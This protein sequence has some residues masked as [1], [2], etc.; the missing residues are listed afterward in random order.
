[1]RPIANAQLEPPGWVR[2]LVPPERTE[3]EIHP[4]PSRLDL[5]ISRRCSPHSALISAIAPG[6]VLLSSEAFRQMTSEVYAAILA[7]IPRSFHPAR[8]WNHIPDIHAAMGDGLDRYMVFNLGRRS[9]LSEHFGGLRSIARC[10]PTATGVGHGSNELV[11][12]CLAL[13]DRPQYIENPRQIAAYQYS[14]QYG[15]AS[16]SFSRATLVNL[17]GASNRSLIVGGTSSVRGEDTIAP[18]SLGLQFDETRANLD[19]LVKHAFGNDADLGCFESVRAYHTRE[20]DEARVR[21]AVEQ[22]FANATVIELVQ[23]EICRKP[24]LI[25]IEGVAACPT[26]R[27]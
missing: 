9:A 1:M 19:A 24:L 18:D 20:R 22:S 6:A 11:I 27:A 3:R 23:A 17:P 25:E 2:R 15:P 26:S 4:S 16:P 5:V 12:H 8:F 13:D 7:L 10:A 21:R 14:D